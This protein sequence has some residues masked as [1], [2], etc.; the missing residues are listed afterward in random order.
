MKRQVDRNRQPSRKYEV[1][2]KVLLDVTNLNLNVPSKKLSSRRVG[3]F[4][5]TKIVG[6]GAYR[7]RLPAH[8]KAVHPTF[9]EAYLSPHTGAFAKHQEKPTPPPPE[10]INGEKEYLVEEVLNSRKAGS[11]SAVY[12]I[13]WV[14]YSRED[15]SWQPWKNL[16]NAKSSVH[17]FHLKNPRKP[18][19]KGY[20]DWLEQDGPS[21]L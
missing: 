13:K 10:I 17:E 21:E 19:A 15:N 16:L 3:P 9:N 7:L 4:E 1:G 18:S 2:D 11:N 5:I 14:G 6:E 20:R 12:Y 8:W